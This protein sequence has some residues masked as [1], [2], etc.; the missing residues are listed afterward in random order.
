MGLAQRRWVPAGTLLAACPLAALLCVSHLTPSSEDAL[1]EMMGVDPERLIEV[2]EVQ[3]ATDAG[4]QVPL[5]SL[6][7]EDVERLRS[8]A[9]DSY[10]V[11]DRLARLIRTAEPDLSY[12]CH[13]WVFAAGRHW[14][15]GRDVDP[16]L[17]GNGYRKVA[18]PQA[19]DVVVYRS[20]EGSTV[21]HTRLVRT[22]EPGLVLIES[23][24]GALGRYVHRAEDQCYGDNFAFYHADR[25]GHALTGLDTTH[26]GSTFPAAT[27]RLRRAG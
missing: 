22:V 21:L 15:K 27:R 4:L 19:G 8:I 25:Q 23:K 18:V 20:R 5:Y 10:V 14:I 13:G 11:R 17:T 3:A 26:P 6:P 9:S 1:P 16:I 2:T 12:N 7:N 24:W